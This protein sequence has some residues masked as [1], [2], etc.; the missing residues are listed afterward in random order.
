[1]AVG[2]DPDYELL[3]QDSLIV[4]DTFNQMLLALQLHVQCFHVGFLPCRWDG[5][6]WY[7]ENHVVISIC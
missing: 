2:T 6:H 3:L 7:F 5:V 1:M 4:D